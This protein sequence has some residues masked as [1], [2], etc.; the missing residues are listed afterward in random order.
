MKVSVLVGFFRPDLL[1][2]V[3]CLDASDID[4]V[5]KD[6][7]WPGGPDDGMH[8]GWGWFNHGFGYSSSNYHYYDDEFAEEEARK[9]RPT[10]Y[11]LKSK[12]CGIIKI[13]INRQWSWNSGNE[14]QF[15]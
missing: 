2:I 3:L 6:W 9:N 1:Y 4:R 13:L 12:A 15:S 14:A 7:S 10:N 11:Y 5:D 8:S